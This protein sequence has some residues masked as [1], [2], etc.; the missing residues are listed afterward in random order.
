[1]YI[2]V[3]FKPEADELLYSWLLRLAQANGFCGYNAEYSFT[4]YYMIWYK[5]S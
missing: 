5:K 2:P 3:C 1:M 4:D